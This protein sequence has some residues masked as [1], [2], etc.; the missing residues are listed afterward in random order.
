MVR[1]VLVPAVM[2][3]LGDKNWWI[4]AWLEK[5]LPTLDVEKV[6]AGAEGRA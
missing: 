6:P 2:E 4:P 5:I 1:L 3:L